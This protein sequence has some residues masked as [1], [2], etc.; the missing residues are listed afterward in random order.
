MN[1]PER[2][3]EL[4]KPHD[5]AT[6]SVEGAGAG[7][8]EAQN[9]QAM[10]VLVNAQIDP[11][12]RTFRVRVGIDNSRNLFK[13]GT[14]AKVTI[15]IRTKRDAVVVPAEAITFTKGE[16]AAFVVADGVV[17][18]RPVVLGIASRT[19]Y[20]IVSGLSESDQVVKGDLSLLATGLH[21]RP[22]VDTAPA[23]P[24]TT[25]TVAAQSQRLIDEDR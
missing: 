6:V 17:E 15:P 14:F 9:V 16:P 11:E 3:Q 8:R 13:A 2:Y 21:V 12:T 4:I 20:Q 24:T 19:H 25:T 22:R 10:V 5:M 7:N 18:K 1:V 23:T